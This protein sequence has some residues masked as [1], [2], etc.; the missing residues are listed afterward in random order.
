MLGLEIFV[1]VFNEIEINGM[2]LNWKYDIWAPILIMIVALGTIR[3][4]K[5][6]DGL[7]PH[8]PWSSLLVCPLEQF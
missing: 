3:K 6:G 2:L 4:T 5:W 7:L 8:Y 1:A